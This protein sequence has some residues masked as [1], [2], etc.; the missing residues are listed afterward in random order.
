MGVRKTHLSPR[1]VKILL[2]AFRDGIIID[3]KRR[4]VERH[5]P[6]YMISQIGLNTG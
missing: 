6:L 5:I 3:G 2:K 4:R 1:E